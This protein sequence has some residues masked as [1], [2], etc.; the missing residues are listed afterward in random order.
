M[1]LELSS[2]QHTALKL[3]EDMLE[4][5]ELTG[6]VRAIRLR[7]D[8][9]S[10]SRIAGTLG[11]STA[12]VNEWLDRFQRGGPLALL[13]EPIRP[14]IAQILEA[15][16]LDEMV[17]EGAAEQ[18]P[19]HPPPVAREGIDERWGIP[20]AGPV[21][22]ASA[23]TPEGMMFLLAI[24]AT[25]GRLRHRE[26]GVFLI[27]EDDGTGSDIALEDWLVRNGCTPERAQVW[28]ERARRYEGAV[29]TCGPPEPDEQARGDDR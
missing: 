8:G 18:E 20:D 14:I 7:A 13:P 23:R 2:D 21:R 29:K 12:D 25:E 15:A 1:S 28:I 10:P 16:G 5:E 24:D 9:M 26:N 27:G 6:P 17:P 22:G 19:Q 11:C 3:L 4:G